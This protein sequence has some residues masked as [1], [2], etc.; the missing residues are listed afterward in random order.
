MSGGGQDQLPTS[1]PES[2]SAKNL[3]SPCLLGE[4]VWT[5]F[6]L[7]MLSPK[8][9]KIQIPFVN[10]GWGEMRGGALDY[11]RH[12]VRIWGEL[13]NFDKKIFHSLRLS[14]SVRRLITDHDNFSGFTYKVT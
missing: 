4:G 7:L 10:G 1:D 8:L 3:I 9:P 5:N 11:V 6:P 12:L 14:A 13:L 2:K